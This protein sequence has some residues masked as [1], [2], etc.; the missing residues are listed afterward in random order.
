MNPSIPLPAYLVVVAPM[1]TLE[2]HGPH[3]LLLRM[4]QDPKEK[5]RVD[6]VVLDLISTAE[7]W[8]KNGLDEWVEQG[9]KRF[10]R[11]TSPDDSELFPRLKTY[12]ENQISDVRVILD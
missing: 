5:P 3:G 6:L 11:I 1:K 12:I 10:H 7:G 9:D 8:A 2:I 4:V